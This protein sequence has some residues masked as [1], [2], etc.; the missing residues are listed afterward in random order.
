[1]VGP[2]EWYNQNN[3]FN[4]PTYYPSINRYNNWLFITGVVYIRN[5]GYTSVDE[6]IDGWLNTY[7]EE[8]LNLYQGKNQ[9]SHVCNYCSVFNCKTKAEI[10]AHVECL[11]I[12][13]K[14]IGTGIIPMCRSHNSERSNLG[15]KYPCVYEYNDWYTQVKK[16]RI[17]WKMPFKRSI[18]LSIHEVLC[19]LYN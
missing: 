14:Y 11:D 1:M 6:N 18:A 19:D 7:Y 15:K 10:G 3:N 2:R 5:V 9:K 13:K 16:D 12:N 17:L 8:L 4:P